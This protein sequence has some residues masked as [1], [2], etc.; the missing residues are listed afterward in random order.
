M[1][2]KSYNLNSFQSQKYFFKKLKFFYEKNIIKKLQ[3]IKKNLNF[4]EMKIIFFS[5]T[6]FLNIF[7]KDIA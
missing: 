2:G 7:I 5:I 3:K 4:E 1:L 6:L